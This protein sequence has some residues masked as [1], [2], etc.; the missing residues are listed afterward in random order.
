M[1][2][3]NVVI[4]LLCYLSILPA[5]SYGHTLE[6]QDKALKAQFKLNQILPPLPRHLQT[7]ASQYIPIAEYIL[8]EDGTS[9]KIEV[10]NKYLLIIFLRHKKFKGQVAWAIYSISYK[11]KLKLKRFIVLNRLEARPE[12]IYM[13]D[14]I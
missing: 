6:L 13:D 14:A 7:L 10:E 5:C 9:Y 2:K 1:K 8:R 11:G 3:L 12:I 4:M